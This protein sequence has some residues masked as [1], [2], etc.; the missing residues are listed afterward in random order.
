[1]SG[2]LLISQLEFYWDVHL[3]PRLDGLTDAEYL[4]EPAKPSWTVHPDATGKFVIDTED[5][6]PDPPPI[7]TI[8][9]RLVHIGVGCFATRWN[10]FFGDGP[11]DAD[12]FDPRQ[13]PS[14][15]PGTADAGIAFLEHWYGRWM[16]AIKGLGEDALNEPLGPK[17]SFFAQDSML[18][19]IAHI[20]RE[21]MH[22]GGEICLLRD[23]YRAGVGR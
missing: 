9:W 13:L 22:H 2:E 23:L 19:L 11:E 10:T 17:G 15:L 7:T 1:M 8:A 21:A 16:G 4:W 6:V 3:R 20:N 12:M 14:E 18:G 5:P